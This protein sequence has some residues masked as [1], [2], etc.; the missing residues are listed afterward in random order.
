MTSLSL[1]PTP[2]RS[3]LNVRNVGPLPTAKGASYEKGEVILRTYIWTTLSLCN[4]LLIDLNNSGGFNCDTHLIYLQGMQPS[5]SSFRSFCRVLRGHLSP[6]VPN[7]ETST[8]DHQWLGV[9]AQ[10][11]G[12][13]R[14]KAAARTLRKLG[15]ISDEP[16]ESDPNRWREFYTESEARRH[17]G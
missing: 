5:G 3:V 12:E 6:R 17:F 9:R 16:P 10:G 4:C 14:Q 7:M 8:Q 2:I 15:T 13:A 1:G 11:N